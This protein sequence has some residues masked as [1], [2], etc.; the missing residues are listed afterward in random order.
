[1]SCFSCGSGFHSECINLN[2]GI[3]CCKAVPINL[4]EVVSEIDDDEDDE[5]WRKKKRQGKSDASLK[6]QQSTGRKRAAVLF[7]LDRDAPCEWQGL[8]F[9][10]G[11]SSPIIGCLAGKQQA[12][13]HG[14]NKDTLNN[15]EGNVHRICHQCHNRWHTRND[16]GYQWGAISR[17]PHDPDTKST[18]QE[19]LDAEMLW[20]KTKVIKAK[21]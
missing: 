9:A 15:E 5:N 6:D 21:D 11:G 12:R 7:P 18:P 1:M 13:H 16:P 4:D 14:P 19:F 10:G 3:C 20:A 2:D 8:K 17:T